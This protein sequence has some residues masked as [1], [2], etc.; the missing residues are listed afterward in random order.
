MLIN[1]VNNFLTL[2]KSNQMGQTITILEAV[3]IGVI[4][5]V[6]YAI[7]KSLIQVFTTQGGENNSKN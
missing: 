5:I 6:L 7:L 2:I 3:A 4:T 1:Y